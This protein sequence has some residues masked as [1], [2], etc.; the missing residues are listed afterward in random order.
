[1][2]YINKFLIEWGSQSRFSIDPLDNGNYRIHLMGWSMART[3][4]DREFGDLKAGLRVVNQWAKES[5]EK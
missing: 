4:I 1:M 5:L 3:E 2:K